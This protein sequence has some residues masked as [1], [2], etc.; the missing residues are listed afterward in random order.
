[1]VDCFDADFGLAAF[2]FVAFVAFVA[3]GLAF[4][5]AAAL[6]AGAVALPVGN[7]SRFFF[8]TFLPLLENTVGSDGDAEST[9]GL[10]DAIF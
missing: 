3:L 1:M 9:T 7:T 2:G 4:R 5:L 8:T 10:I 6:A